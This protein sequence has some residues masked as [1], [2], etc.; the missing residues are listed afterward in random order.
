[1]NLFRDYRFYEVLIAVL[2]TALVTGFIGA[3]VFGPRETPKQR[4]LRKVN[5]V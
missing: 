5:K 2:A 3:H 4:V 1:M